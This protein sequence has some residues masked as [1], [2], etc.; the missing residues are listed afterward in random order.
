M[1]IM[2]NF[3]INRIKKNVA[4]SQYGNFTI[5][6][7]GVAPFERQVCLNHGALNFV[8]YDF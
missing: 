2:H 5:L 8:F 6:I 1:K 4:V 3:K 7:L